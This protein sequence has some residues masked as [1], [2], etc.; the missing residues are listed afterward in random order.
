MDI[1]RMILQ[2]L[3]VLSALLLI[4]LVLLHSPKGEGGMGMFG[5]SSQIFAS[6]KGAEATL[7]KITTSVAATFFA[8][9]FVLGYFF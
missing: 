2:G 9:S 7:N 3:Q 1:V 8:V 5:G 6:Q 4:L